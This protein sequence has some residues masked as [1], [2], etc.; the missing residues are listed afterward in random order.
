MIKHQTT[1][2]NPSNSLMVTFGAFCFLLLNNT[3][4]IFET[5]FLAGF[6]FSMNFP[7]LSQMNKLSIPY[8]FI[9]NKT[10]NT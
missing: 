6:L 5:G 9:H 1:F 3:K 2:I 7:F 4:N 8:N 10:L